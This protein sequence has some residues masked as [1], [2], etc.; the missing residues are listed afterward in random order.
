MQTGNPDAKTGLF[1]EKPMDPDALCDAGRAFEQ[2][3][4]GSSNKRF[5]RGRFQMDQRSIC[6]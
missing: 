2:I 5:E 4:I 3:Q 1:W 6:E